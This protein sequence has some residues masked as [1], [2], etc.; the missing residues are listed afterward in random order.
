[1]LKRS[2]AAAR[3]ASRWWSAPMRFTANAI[4]AIRSSTLPRETGS[5]L[6]Q[7]PV[8][9]RPLDAQS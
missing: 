4:D 6:K 2:N 8:G 1:M 3:R 5:W 7:T 9:I